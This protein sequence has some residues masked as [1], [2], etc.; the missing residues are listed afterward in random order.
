MSLKLLELALL[1]RARLVADTERA[2][3]VIQL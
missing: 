2:P 1:Q 3:V